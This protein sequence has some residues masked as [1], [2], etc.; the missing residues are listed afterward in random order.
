MT[1]RP[2]RPEDLFAGEVRLRLW[3]LAQTNAHSDKPLVLMLHGM[4]DVSRS[5][6]PV[7]E[8]LADSFTV[9][10][11]DQRG[12]GASDYPGAYSIEH[13][14]FDLH[15][16]IAHLQK[17]IGQRPLALVGHSLGG[18][19]AARFAGLFPELLDALV[20]IEGLGPPDPHWPADPVARTQDVLRYRAQILD[21]YSIPARSRSLPS[22]EFA[23]NRLRVN[24]PRLAADQALLAARLATHLQLDEQGNEQRYWAFDQ[25]V[26]TAL[27]N[28]STAEG[29]PL[30]QA[31]RCPTLSITGDLSYEYWCAAMGLPD[32]YSGKFQAGEYEAR[33][34][35][36][37]DIEHLRFDNSGHMIHFDEPQRLARA[38]QEFLQR[39]LS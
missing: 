34:S 31:T 11:L 4:R 6:L 8:T 12:H 14:Y 27:V 18:Q 29:I 24:N 3:H 28:L 21:R 25:R 35:N 15:R 26:A 39:K 10:L 23:A 5:L 19:I 22:V 2:L 36:F 32:D 38:T 33:I 9:V 17:E 7:A 20:L 37:A 1:E 30:W 13:F 16:V